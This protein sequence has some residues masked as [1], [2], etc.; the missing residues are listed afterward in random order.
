MTFSVYRSLQSNNT[1]LISRV[2]QQKYG[3]TI[4]SFSQIVGPTDWKNRRR[5]RC[6]PWKLWVAPPVS[7]HSTVRFDKVPNRVIQKWKTRLSKKMHFRFQVGWLD[8]IK[9]WNQRRIIH[10]QGIQKSQS[11]HEDWSGWAHESASWQ[12]LDQKTLCTT[13]PQGICNNNLSWS[14]SKN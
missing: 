6:L 9:H 14:T 13:I 7:L 8:E 4:R 3:S 10:H 12:I 5:G 1:F 11:L 2:N